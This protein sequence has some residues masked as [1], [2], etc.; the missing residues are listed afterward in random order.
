M[1]DDILLV[2]RR[3]PATL[4]TLNR[5]DARNALSSPLLARIRAELL[6]AEQDPN[7]RGIVLTGNEKFFSAGA[8]LK[9]AMEAFMEKRPAS[10]TGTRDICACR[11]LPAL[12]PPPFQRPKTGKYSSLC[13]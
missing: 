4:L 10:F 13:F 11:V 2:E 6:A 12:Y 7:I 8:D 5:P 9:E 1:S 3:A